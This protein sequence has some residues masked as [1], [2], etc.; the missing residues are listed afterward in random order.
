MVGD[1]EQNLSAV[2]LVLVLLQDSYGELLLMLGEL[3]L[4][5]YFSFLKKLERSPDG[6]FIR[7]MS[8]CRFMFLKKIKRSYGFLFGLLDLLCNKLLLVQAS[9]TDRVWRGN[10]SPIQ[11]CY[12]A[13]NI[14]S[15]K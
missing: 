10:A 3:V 8:G 14:V 6:L 9:D 2:F 15:I 4:L 13:R 1:T 12:N 11:F 7:H 5:V